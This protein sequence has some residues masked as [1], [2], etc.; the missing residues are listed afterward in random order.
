MKIVLV[1]KG[2]KYTIRKRVILTG[3]APYSS[4]TFTT[5]TLRPANNGIKFI[6]GRETIP[7]DYKH[8]KKTPDGQHASLVGNSHINIYHTEHILAALAGMGVSSVDIILDVNQVPDIDGSAKAFTQKIQEVGRKKIATHETF[9]CVQEEIF[10]GK[11]DS[12]AVIR[13]SKNRRIS[14][15]IQFP[16]PIGEQYYSFKFTRKNYVKELS[17]A[18]SFI[19]KG[20]D[21]QVWDAARRELPRLPEDMKKSHILVFD[22]KGKWIVSPKRPDEAVR[23]KIVDVIGDLALLGYP[24]LGEITIIRP[25]HDFNRKLVNYLGGILESEGK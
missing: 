2:F 8:T 23:H 16:E 15:L 22:K 1:K 21:K 24:I 7:V 17:W 25:G 3:P 20:C 10:F 9:A 19:R 18:R 13:P 12:F 4:N 6:I 14:A 5:L 11:N